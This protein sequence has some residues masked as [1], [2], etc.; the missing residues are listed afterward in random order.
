LN[1]INSI[2]SEL[3]KLKYL[4]IF[5]LVAFVCVIIWAIMI[6]MHILDVNGAVT[7]SGSPWEKMMS[8]LGGIVSVFL[9]SPFVILLIGAALYI[10]HQAKGWKHLYALP[11]KRF[12]I[13][14]SK[15]AAILI[16]ALVGFLIII[17][18]LLICGYIINTIFPEYEFNLYAPPVWD[19]TRSLGQ[20]FVSILGIIGIQFFLSVRFKGFLIPASIGVI[21]FI[22]G[23][24]LA[25][26]NKSLALFL[27]YS[28]PMVAR[29]RGMFKVDKV[30]IEEWGIFT[31][32]EWFSIGVF[33]FFVVSTLI[34]E[35]RK[36]V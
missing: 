32:V 33:L 8:A 19:M 15:L 27:P 21:A 18:G 16:F 29:D 31:N 23:L 7:L 5:W 14:L 25:T 11:K 30:G 9:A 3:I 10:E 36:N 17:P 34:L 4:P 24:I 26:T 20:I 6:T 12:S 13:I 2:R 22:V 28:Y 35:S 1:F